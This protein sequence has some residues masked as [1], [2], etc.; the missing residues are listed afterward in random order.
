MYDCTA[1]DLMG[2]ANLFEALY[3]QEG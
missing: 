2:A 3:N 1:F